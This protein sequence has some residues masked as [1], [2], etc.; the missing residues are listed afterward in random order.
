[1]A[2]RE[3]SGPRRLGAEW[4]LDRIVC[5]RLSMSICLPPWVSKRHF[6]A[7]HLRPERRADSKFPIAYTF[8]STRTFFQ[9]RVM[10]LSVPSIV[11]IKTALFRFGA[12]RG[13]HMLLDTAARDTTWKTSCRAGSIS[14]CDLACESERLRPRATSFFRRIMCVGYQIPTFSLRAAVPSPAAKEP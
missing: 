9:K 8:W 14:R 2:H 5:E 12:A 13:S 7:S 1:M 10:A 3:L 11:A 4:I 6:F